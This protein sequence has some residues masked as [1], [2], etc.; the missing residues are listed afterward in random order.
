M[1]LEHADLGERDQAGQV[2]HVGIGRGG[3]AP[4]ADPHA[5]DLR[6]NARARVLLVEALPA[7]AFRT[8]H[9][10]E[11]PV[12]HVGHDEVRDRLVVAR[13]PELGDGLLP[14]EHAIGMGQ[15]D[16]GHRHVRAAAARDAAGRRRAG[17]LAHDLGGG[18]V[19]AQARE[20]RVAQEP[21]ARPLGERHLAHQHRLDP[22]GAA[23]GRPRT[24]G[25]EGR[26][27][28]LEPAQPSAEH[29]E[30]G[31][32]EAG[33]DAARVD[34]AAV[35]IV[36]AQQQ[37]AELGAG[38]LRIGVA[39]DHELLPRHALDLQPCLPA[40]GGVGRVLPLR[41]DALEAHAAGPLVDLRARRV[42]VLG[43][44]D[45]GRA[46][47]GAAARAPSSARSAAG[48]GDPGR[49][50][51]AGRRPR[52]RGSAPSRPRRPAGA[53]GR[54]RRRPGPGPRSRRRGSPP[55]P[56]ARPPP[57]PPRGSARSS[58]GGCA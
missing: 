29:L 32:G 5:L 45:A 1:D 33:A 56:G 46:G 6:G 18:L 31:L 55:S 23:R 21:V 16:A 24:V 19:L 25:R 42:E 41:H 53:P 7:R 3:A 38:A 26:G 54:R 15:V 17:R 48:S 51:T 4:L 10:A 12:G 49:R 28:L 22:V 27:A 44:A 13:E 20:S 2:V 9:Q 14:V 52:R 36:H 50:G 40:P 39:A 34:E 11:R 30:G 58:P 8:A 43:V 35:A 47:R 37:R 57:R